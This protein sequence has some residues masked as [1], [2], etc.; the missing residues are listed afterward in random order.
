MG[1]LGSVVLIL[2]GALANDGRLGKRRADV[3]FWLQALSPLSGVL[4]VSA[5]INGLLCVMQML[6][7]LGF[8]RHAPTVWIGTTTAGVV[9]LLLG[10][11]FG[12]PLLSSLL[13]SRLG[14]LTRS[15]L[16][17]LHAQLIR[18][19]EPL[20][21]AGIAFGLFCVAINVIK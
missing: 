2:L 7:Y 1:M 17:R 5:A 16:E 13:G 20:G 10:L 8:I 12:Y 9:S 6:A 14:E 3:R 15:R 11:R 4:G 21:A 19:Q 18:S